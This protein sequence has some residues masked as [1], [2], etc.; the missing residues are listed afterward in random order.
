M[1]EFISRILDNDILGDKVVQILIAAIFILAVLYYFGFINFGLLCGDSSSSYDSTRT[2]LSQT[3][4]TVDPLDIGFANP[5]P[6]SKDLMDTRGGRR[7]WEDGL[8][9]ACTSH[10]C[11]DFQPSEV[12][13]DYAAPL[14][15]GGGV[16]YTSTGDQI[17]IVNG[18]DFK[19]E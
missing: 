16:V 19:V 8:F 6:N 7:N 12:K 11:N 5:K 10:S 3:M 4:E 14:R 13:N 2:E 17:M 18:A 1:S 9:G 15:E